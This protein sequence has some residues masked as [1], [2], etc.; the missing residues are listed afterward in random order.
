M[1]RKILNGEEHLIANDPVRPHIPFEKRVG[2]GREV[3]VLEGEDKIRAVICVAYTNDI[4]IDEETLDNYTS[5]KGTNA[6]FYTVWSYDKGAGRE[7]VN[8]GLRHL[9]ENKPLIKRFVTLS[10]LTDMAKNFHIRNG[11]SLISHN[12]ESYNFEYPAS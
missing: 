8:Q 2:E 11:A 5:A 4:P 7:I 12:P 3:F 6:I 9:K 1:I 10:P